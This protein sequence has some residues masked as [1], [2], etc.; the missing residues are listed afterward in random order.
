MGDWR[1]DEQKTLSVPEKIVGTPGVSYTYLWIVPAK[2][3]GRW[4]SEF[5]H[6][7]GSTSIEFEFTQTYQMVGGSAKIGAQPLKL[8]DTRMI[9]DQITFTVFAKAGDAAT[10]HEFHGTVKG[11]VIDGTVTIGSGN[12][13]KE[14]QWS[15]KRMARAGDAK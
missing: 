5:K 11:D 12:T 8:P 2:V 6:G 10:R 4:Q 14:L 9:G 13:Q 7:T 15:A 3:G 1:P